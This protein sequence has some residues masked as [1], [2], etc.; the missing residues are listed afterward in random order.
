[1]KKQNKLYTKAF[2][3]TLS[4]KG[5]AWPVPM[6]IH[7]R[8]IGVRFRQYDNKVSQKLYNYIFENK[9]YNNV[10][11]ST[12][13]I[14]MDQLINMRLKE[15]GKQTIIDAFDLDALKAFVVTLKLGGI[16][17]ADMVFKYKM[18]GELGLNTS[19]GFSDF[20]QDINEHAL[21]LDFEEINSRAE[22]AARQIS[23]A[24][25][26]EFGYRPEI[27]IVKYEHPEG[28]IKDE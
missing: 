22:E 4:S 27:S 11:F 19:V 23:D 17:D 8:S 14:K 28:G 26:K 15:D 3:N 13:D 25:K 20:V 6:I 16:K 7:L 1:M 24:A 10:T 2:S 21:T 12:I 5:S 18:H 9:L